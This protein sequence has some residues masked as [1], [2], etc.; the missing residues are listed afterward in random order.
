MNK[1]IN[2]SRLED[3]LT[4]VAIA[5][6]VVLVATF[7]IKLKDAQHQIDVLDADLNTSYELLDEARS[8]IY[9]LERQVNALI[10][11]HYTKN[12]NNQGRS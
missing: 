6:G 12:N 9:Q 7:I 3:I 11:E 5:L 8:D 2:L 1:S 10:E 4:G